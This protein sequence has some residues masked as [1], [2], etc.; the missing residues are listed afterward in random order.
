MNKSQNKQIFDVYQTCSVM[1]ISNLNT[2]FEKLTHLDELHIRKL[3]VDESE[4]IELW[5][6]IITVYEKITII[7][8]Y[9]RFFT[10]EKN[11]NDSKIEIYV[12]SYN[13]Y[14]KYEIFLDNKIRNFMIG[15]LPITLDTLILIPYVKRGEDNH[16]KLNL[17]ECPMHNLPSNLKIL[18]IK[19]TIYCED[20]SEE[21]LDIIIGTIKIPHSCKFILENITFEAYKM[22]PNSLIILHNFENIEQLFV[23]AECNNIKIINGDEKSI[24]FN[25]HIDNSYNINWW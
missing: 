15:N 23:E 13:E 18:K 6:F 10:I 14:S 20:E 8:I 17:Q 1:L 2:L 3:F 4:I 5:N 7:K 24:I 11:E 22:K 25:K 19:S 12:F 9:S 16:Y 21:I